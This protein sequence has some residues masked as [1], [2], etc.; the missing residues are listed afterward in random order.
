MCCLRLIKAT[1]KI[2]QQSGNFPGSGAF[3][4]LFGPVRGGFEQ[5]FPR[6]VARGVAGGRKLNLRFDWYIMLFSPVPRCG[7][8]YL[9]C[10][11][12]TNKIY[13]F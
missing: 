5:N 3:E 1:E 11:K 8:V 10:C 7:R 12:I 6:G 9:F 4:Q 13:F 2:K